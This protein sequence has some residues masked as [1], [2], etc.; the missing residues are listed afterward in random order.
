MPSGQTLSGLAVAALLLR[1]R[2]RLAK[3]GSFALLLAEDLFARAKIMLQTICTC[4]LY[5][6]YSMKFVKT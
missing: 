6:E 2:R 4:L 5:S 3:T 1:R